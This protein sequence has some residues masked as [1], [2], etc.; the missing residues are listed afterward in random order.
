MLALGAALSFGLSDYTGALAARRAS[1]L[2]I[3]LISSL[4]GLVLT[5]PALLVVPGRLSWTALGYGALAGLAG[6]AGFVLYLRCMAVGPMGVVSPL[7]ALVGAAV[8]VLWGVALAGDE[9]AAAEV[10]GILAGLVAV[11]AVAYTPGTSPLAAGTRGPLFA[12]AAGVG[13]G[14]FF[15]AL[16]ASPA[17]SG[18]WPVIGSKLG[19][20]ALLGVL[21][22]VAPRPLPGRTV[23]PLVLV[24]AVCDALAN[25]LF[26]LAT[27]VGLLSLV[28]LLTSLYP[29]V[30][31]LLAR[32]LL[33]ERLSR[34]QSIGVALALAAT[35]LI[36][37]A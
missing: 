31:L 5:A 30:V 24:S 29:V 37:G 13:F 1:S 11:V 12:L 28:A 20:L 36:V 32:T 16:D 34:L 33:R 15:V 35:A 22:L 19:S 14:L 23:M 7:A 8:P 3:V 10:A 18:L 25:V 2:T 17:D 6:A 21:L 26:L 27:R 4:I 9:L